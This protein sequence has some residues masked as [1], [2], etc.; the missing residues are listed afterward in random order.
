MRFRVSEFDAW[1]EPLGLTTIADKA[2]F[3]G[4]T[5]TSHFFR[6]YKG[7]IGCGGR[8]ASRVLSAPW[9]GRKPPVFEDFFT[10]EV[11]S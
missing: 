9:P 5:E 1:A 8:F 10:F 6:V 4:F 2:R 7:Q 11:A 3:C